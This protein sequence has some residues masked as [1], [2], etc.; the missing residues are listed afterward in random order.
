M[1]P[2]AVDGGQG[3]PDHR[4][5]QGTTTTAGQATTTGTAAAQVPEK[6]AFTAQTVSGGQFEGKSLLGKPAVLWFWAPWCPK[7]QREAAGI[8]S[9]AQRNGGVTFLGVAANDTVEAMRGFIDERGVG[10]F[11]HLA[12]TDAEIWRHFGVAAQPAYAFVSS[13]GEVEVVTQQLAEDELA[14]KVAALS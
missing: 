4:R 6:L 10:G 3:A 2:D 8:A 12:D 11:E 1:R 9:A 7:C 14:A 5:A 13:K